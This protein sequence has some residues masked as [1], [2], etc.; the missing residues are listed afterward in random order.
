MARTTQTTPEASA[1]P[2]RTPLTG[3]NRLSV[4]NKEDGYVYRIVNDIDDRVELL[5]EQ[6]YELVPT[7]KVGAM[8]DRRVDNP[9]PVGSIATISVGNGTKA[10]VMRKRKDWH[11]QD[12]NAKQQEIDAL[13]ATMKKEARDKA[14][15]GTI[16]MSR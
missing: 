1:R 3:R 2:R 4:K 6:D 9:Q 7:A 8:G 10:V 11:E 13:E 16:E 14:D 12:Q 5:T 15:Y